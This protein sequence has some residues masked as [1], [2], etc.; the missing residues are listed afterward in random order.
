MW[1]S[2]HLIGVALFQLVDEILMDNFATQGADDFDLIILTGLWHAEADP[3]INVLA[4]AGFPVHVFWFTCEQ[5]EGLPD[6]GTFAVWDG[7]AR[8]KAG[9]VQLFAHQ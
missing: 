9:R 7:N 4:I 8:T 3:A 1:P 2:E 6:A 5:D